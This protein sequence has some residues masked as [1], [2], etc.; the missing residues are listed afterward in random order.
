MT[1]SAGDKSSIS[2]LHIF[3][4]INARDFGDFLFTQKSGIHC[5]L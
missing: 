1:I 3:V 2:R 5:N 4:D